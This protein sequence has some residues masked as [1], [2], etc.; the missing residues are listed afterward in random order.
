MTAPVIF[1]MFLN[2]FA[3]VVIGDNFLTTIRFDEAL[4]RPHT[5]LSKSELF[6]EL[7]PDRKAIF[8]KSLGTKVI[9][10][11]NV[12]TQSGKLYSFLIITGERPHSFVQIKDGKQDK[13]FKDVYTSSEV[14][15]Q[16][17]VYSARVINKTR[18]IIQINS[19]EIPS[20]ARYDL[21]KG[22]PIFLNNERV[23]R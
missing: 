18:K 4:E 2:A 21:P 7:S 11:L 8:I 13:S 14:I 10:N 17:G 6:L 23:H 9:T 22:A 16:E 20:L 1:Y 15:I 3:P 12:P 5:G 19:I